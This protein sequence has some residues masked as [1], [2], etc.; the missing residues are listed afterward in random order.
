MEGREDGRMGGQEDGR[1]GGQ[2]D[3]RMGERGTGEGGW[4]HRRE[5]EGEKGARVRKIERGRSSEWG[6]PTWDQ[7]MG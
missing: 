3:G 6:I 4:A 7:Q 1:M 5:E 2:E